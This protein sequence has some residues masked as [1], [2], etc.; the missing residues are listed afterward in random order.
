MSTEARATALGANCIVCDDCQNTTYSLAGGGSNYGVFYGD[1]AGSKRGR[2]EGL[3]GTFEAIFNTASSV[4]SDSF[5][6]STDSTILNLAPSRDAAKFVRFLR[7]SGNSYDTQASTYN[8]GHDNLS[9]GSAKR[10]ALRWYSYHAPNYEWAYDGSTGCNNGKIAHSSNGYNTTPLMTLT[11]HGGGTGGNTSLYS[12][13][14]PGWDWL[15][16]G[17]ATWEGFDP[18]SG[19]RPGSPVS[20]YNY[21]GKWFRH[22]V[23]VVN[24]HAADSGGYDFE[25]W[26][27]NITDG[28][29]EVCDIKFSSG[30]SGCL[31]LGGPNFTWDSSIKPDA[32]MI[33]LHTCFY[34]AAD[35]GT[36]C[37]GWQG[38]AYLLLAK[39]D[40][41]AGQRIGAADEVEGG[42]GGS[43]LSLMGQI[44]Q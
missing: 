17:H 26:V 9:L 16:S 37:L 8:F 31:A 42:T 28:T 4:F 23:I 27:K 22:E 30:C 10:L 15:W 25:Y 24:P 41:D 40:T 12:F 34:R 32:N 39:W 35:G 5:A 36:D 7:H 3:D 33:S 2:M 20:C 13:K 21:R 14:D 43:T 6:I 29:A 11:T 38:W 19:P 1:Q 44:L 18:G